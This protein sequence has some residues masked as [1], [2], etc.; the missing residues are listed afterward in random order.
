M[1]APA[2]LRPLKTSDRVT[3]VAAVVL[4]ICAGLVTAL[5]ADA[6][7]RFALAGLALAALAA[8][9]GQAIEQVGER[10]GPSATGLLQSTL[11]NLPELF[12]SIFALQDGLTN[13]VQ[14]ALIGSVLANAVLVLGCA[15]IAGGLRHGT[16]RFDPEEP[17]LHASLLVLVV[18]AL[19]VPT[20]ADHLH[21]PAADHV[22]ALSDACAIALLVVYGASVSFYSPPSGPRPSIPSRLKPDPKTT[23][24][25]GRSG[26]QL[27]CSP[28]P[29]WVRPSRRTGLF[30]L[31]S[32]PSRP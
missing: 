7:V 26:C 19:L 10:I 14:A 12:V 16:Q 1:T 32:R 25:P 27:A 29:A 15:F 9:I 24:H 21:T 18:A 17:R 5:H 20:L 22:S 3:L 28:S 30:L 2:A 6:V 13:L 23:P 4:T 31:C 8:V 11:G